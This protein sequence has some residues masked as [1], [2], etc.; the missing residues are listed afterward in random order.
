MVER[1]GLDWVVAEP[2]LGDESWREWAERNRAELTEAG[3]WGVPS[4]V[5]GPYAAWG[6]DRIW[7][8]E[9]KLKAHFG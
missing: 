4:F 9:Q 7:I 1:A 3:H 8:L 2:M 6:Q 5:L